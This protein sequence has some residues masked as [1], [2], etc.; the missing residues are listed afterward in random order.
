MFDADTNLVVFGP[1][2][3]VSGFTAPM[4]VMPA[5]YTTWARFD[6]AQATR[7]TAIAGASREFYQA[8]AHPVT[9]L[10]PRIAEFSGA[11]LGN[12]NVEACRTH[13]HIALDYY[14][15]KAPFQAEEAERVLDFFTSDSIESPVQ[16][17]EL[18]GMHADE[19]PSFVIM[20][21]NGTLALAAPIEKARPFV[22]AVWNAETPTGTYRYYDG[23]LFL[24]SLLALGG[25]LQPIE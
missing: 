23:M 15:N 19:N 16:R 21:M 9:G 13:L 2:L 10:V 22:Q 18:D 1:E 20:V 5:F 7:W 24:L 17:Y 8:A 12:F 11:A 4:Y 3:G 14:W 6:P 25:E